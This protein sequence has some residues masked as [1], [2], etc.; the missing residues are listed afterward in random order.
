SVIDPRCNASV[1][2]ATDRAPSSSPVS[3]AMLGSSPC[4]ARRRSTR[5]RSHGATLKPSSTG[6]RALKVTGRTAVA[7][8]RTPASTQRCSHFAATRWL[9]VRSGCQRSNSLAHALCPSTRSTATAPSTRQVRSENESNRASAGVASK[10]AITEPFW[11]APRASPNKRRAPLL[12]P[13]ADPTHRLRAAAL[14]RRAE[15]A[16]RSATP[17]ARQRPTAAIEEAG[18]KVVAVELRGTQCKPEGNRKPALQPIR[19]VAEPHASAVVA[20]HP[21]LRSWH[22]SMALRSLAVR[23]PQAH[24]PEST[25]FVRFRESWALGVRRG[26]PFY[27]FVNRE[28]SPPTRRRR[29]RDLDA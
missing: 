2:G 23:R 3:V 18:E 20:Q 1:S 5:S 21:T 29:H 26:A 12:A 7:A 25:L 6:T 15:N 11:I 28:G 9:G 24:A 27:V 13:A 10:E 17:D 16:S 8:T 4:P 22:Q 19:I 14:P